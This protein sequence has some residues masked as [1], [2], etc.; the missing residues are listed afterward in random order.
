MGDDASTTVAGTAALT[1]YDFRPQAAM[2]DQAK[3]NQAKP[4]QAPSTLIADSIIGDSKRVPQTPASLRRFGRVLQVDV[5][6][7][8]AGDGRDVG[9]NLPVDAGGKQLSGLR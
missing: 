3:P 5:D 4:S 2:L 8:I 9:F 6:S 7:L 1:F